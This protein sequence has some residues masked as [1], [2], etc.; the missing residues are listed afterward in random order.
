MPSMKTMLEDSLDSVLQ[1][2]RWLKTWFVLVCVCVLQPEIWPTES[3][4]KLLVSVLVRLNMI[5]LYHN[6]DGLHFDQ[7]IVMPSL[8]TYTKSTD[9][10]QGSAPGSEN[11]DLTSAIGRDH[12]RSVSGNLDP[13]PKTIRPTWFNNNEPHR[14]FTMMSSW[15]SR[16]PDRP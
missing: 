7:G 15:S 8:N 2:H 13:D 3:L 16:F 1:T 5:R 6:N 4:L 9:W 10:K 11:G 12:L 14:V